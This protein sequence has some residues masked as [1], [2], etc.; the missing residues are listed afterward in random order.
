[1]GNNQ[2][3]D[4]P[5]K[6]E[7]KQVIESVKEESVKEDA[8]KELFNKILTVSSQLLKEYRENFLD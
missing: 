1:M 5:K 4:T 6:P 2:S 8:E 7:V 3:S